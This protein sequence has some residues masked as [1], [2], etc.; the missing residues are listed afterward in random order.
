MSE[1]GTIATDS[2]PASTNNL[3]QD[4]PLPRPEPV[5]VPGYK[6]SPRRKQPAEL[7]SALT[8]QVLADLNELKRLSQI[9]P[10]SVDD[11]Q[12]YR[13]IRKRVRLFLSSQRDQLYGQRLEQEVAPKLFELTRRDRWAELVY[14]TV[15]ELIALRS[16]NKPVD[17]VTVIADMI[18]VVAAAYKTATKEHQ[19]GITKNELNRLEQDMKAYLANMAQT[20]NLVGQLKD[21]VAEEEQLQLFKA[22]AEQ[23]T[24]ERQDALIEV[25]APLGD[26]DAERAAVAS[27]LA[28]MTPKGEGLSTPVRQGLARA[29]LDTQ[30]VDENTCTMLDLAL[31][32]DDRELIEDV[33]IYAN[34]ID[35]AQTTSSNSTQTRLISLSL[36][37]PTSSEQRALFPEK[38]P[39]NPSLSITAALAMI[40]YA[41]DPSLCLLLKKLKVDYPQEAVLPKEIEKA[42]QQRMDHNLN[43]AACFKDAT[44]CF[45]ETLERFVKQYNT[46]DPVYERHYWAKLT[47]EFQ[48][49]QKAVLN[50]P[51][52]DAMPKIREALLDSSIMKERRTPPGCFD[53]GTWTINTLRGMHLHLPKRKG[54]ASVLPSDR[55]LDQVQHSIE[56]KQ[57]MESRYL[58]AQT[59]F[60]ELLRHLN[61]SKEWYIKKKQALLAVIDQFA[62]G[63]I[64]TAAQLVEAFT[65][66]GSNIY[67]ILYARKD[68]KTHKA[69][70][71]FGYVQDALAKYKHL[72]QDI[73]QLPRPSYMAL[74]QGGA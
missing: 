8:K 66:K 63:K 47:E 48:I 61:Q 44:A 62:S 21:L 40:R 16:E 20:Q 30:M 74:T 55:L 26:L 54:H 42:L 4:N 68:G 24:F 19:A 52:P 38:V 32:L 35:A 17:V 27:S 45:A 6:L 3:P 70:S 71:S 15:N 58:L 5:V 9:E 14:Q 36:K 10:Q 51:T 23:Q 28:S 49:I 67:Q 25:S 12:R 69:S 72:L 50:N 59:V 31:Q 65:D 11:Q 13:K 1:I 56:Q 37:L 73:Q 7:T 39:A 57:G 41:N 22:Q 33:L 29:T 2:S 60:K 53:K 18:E 34:H 64:E 46:G 43:A